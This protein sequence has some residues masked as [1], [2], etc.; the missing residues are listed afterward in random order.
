MDWEPDR[1]F[2]G[3][4]MSIPGFGETTERVQTI[5]IVARWEK[6]LNDYE[7]RKS[8]IHATGHYLWIE[9]T[10]HLL[11]ADT[12]SNDSKDYGITSLAF[13]G[14]WM[15]GELEQVKPYFLLGGGPTYLFADIDGMGSDINGNYQLGFGLRD[16]PVF[17]SKMEI[18]IKYHHISN[19]NKAKPNIALNSVRLMLS[20]PY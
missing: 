11:V 18:Q 10:A 6:T 7:L 17:G 16:I 3:Y 9:A 15:F 20:I 4:G 8:L 2:S 14:V 19:L 5:D 12:D 13:L 1:Y